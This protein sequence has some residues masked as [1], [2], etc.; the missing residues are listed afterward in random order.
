MNQSWAGNLK[1]PSRRV[2]TMRLWLMAPLL[3]ASL[4]GCVGD[5][6]ADEPVPPAPKQPGQGID[7]E[8]LSTDQYDVLP[9]VREYVAASSDGILLHVQIHLPDG[10]GPWPTI[11]QHSPYNTHASPV[12]RAADGFVFDLGE[13][14]Q[15]LVDRYV[16]KGYAVVIGDVRGTGDSEGCMEMM[17]PLERQDTY[18]L[19]QWI[20]QQDWSNG[21]VGMQGVSYVGTTPH[22]ALVMAPPN[23]DTVVTVAG[24]TNQWRN[25]F[26][27][28]VPYQGRFYPITY[29]VLEGAP[30]PADVDRGPAWALNAAAAACGQEG[31]LAAMRPDVYAKGVYDAYW[32]DRNQTALVAQANAGNASILYSQGF[33]DRA[34]NPMEAV[35]WFNDLTVPKKGFFHQGGHQYPPREDYF[36]TELAWFDYWLKDIQNGVMDTPTVEVQLN[37]DDIRVGTTWPPVAAETETL[38]LW[39][40]PEA[41]AADAPADGGQSYVA[42]QALN[43]V[44]GFD[45]VGAADTVASA[46]AG[47][48]T[49]LTFTSDPLDADV[50]MSGSAWMHLV[51]S[52]DAEN[53]YWLFDLYDEN[54]EGARTW[55]AEGWFNAHLH[56][57]FD[58]STPLVP[59]EATMF[60]FA[61]EPREYVLQEEHRIVLVLNGHDSGVLPFDQPITENTV[62][63]G[64]EG[65][66]LDVPV[67]P[68]AKRW[69]RPD[70]V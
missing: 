58:T 35:D 5:D 25:T 50:I 3:I 61:F 32:H 62:H 24:V 46:A 54:P 51:G 67:L 55:L 11:F 27:N 7:W 70:T 17:G 4:A 47:M 9:S 64:A 30:P 37:T 38:R 13:P 36:D 8:M 10:E 28:G 2:P 43:P 57:G 44:A 42:A 19:V 1:S 14:G 21:R 40:A 69:P 52:V 16:P 53:T 31:A 23:L 56:A 39:L 65:S 49:S 12:E 63:Y 20:A 68:D 66:Y 33:V 15:G 59:G 45:F 34:V 6:T 60:D 22:E 41:L 26:Q 18:D 29:E 48:P